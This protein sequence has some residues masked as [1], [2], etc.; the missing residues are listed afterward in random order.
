LRNNPTDA[1][2]IDLSR[3]PSQ[4]RDIA[5]GIR[6]QKTTR[7][8]PLVFVEGETEKIARIKEHL[9]D[10]VYT[11]WSN[12]KSALKHTIAYPPKDPVVPRSRM[13]GYSGTPL[14]K[15]LGIKANSVVTLVNAPKDFEKT[16]GE[17]PEGATS[18]REN[19]N[20]RDLTIWFT[21]SIKE[22]E[23]HIEKIA[24]KVEK[25]KLWIAWPKRTSGM[26]SDVTQNYVRKVGLASG[27][28][29]YKICSI[30]KTWSGLLFVK[31]NSK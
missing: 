3:L 18:Q 28:V 14:V 23:N 6:H 1:V 10:A 25:G 29:D 9:P 13:A 22:L 19:R 12:I 15:K 20:K 17:L 26:T 8:L 11:T 4:G 2:V 30:D 16:L 7:Y 24:G 21:T 27:L 5:L 31:R